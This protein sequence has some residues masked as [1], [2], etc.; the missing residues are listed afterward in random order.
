MKQ[1]NIRFENFA[2]FDV[3]AI[4]KTEWLKRVVRTDLESPNR[5][6]PLNKLIWIFGLQNLLGKGKAFELEDR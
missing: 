6:P 5:F 3:F 1:V 4:E 2:I